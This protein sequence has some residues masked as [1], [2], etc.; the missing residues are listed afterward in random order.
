MFVRRALCVVLVCVAGAASAQ[1]TINGCPIFPAN[2][3]WNVP[4]DGLPVDA[5]SAAILSNMNPNAGLHP[6]FGSGLWDGG[7]IGIPFDA[8]PQSQALVAIDFE[9]LGWPDE[10]DAGPYPIPPDPQ[11]EGEPGA[12]NGDRH[13]LLVQ[14]GTCILWELYYTYPDGENGCDAPSNGWCAASGAKWDLNSNALRPDTW[15]SGDAAGLP[16]L[17]G[18]VRFEEVVAGEIRHALRFTVAPTRQ[19]Y[20]WPAR[21]EAG[22]T[23]N[24]DYP[25]MG[26]RVRLKAGVDLGGFSPHARTILTAL[27]K[28]GMMVADNGGDW[29]ISGIPN[30]SWDNDVLHEIGAIQGS[31]FEVVD[32]SS[33]M[34]DPNSGATSSSPPPPP[35]SAQIFAN[36]FEAGIASLAQWSS[37]VP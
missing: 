25:S 21:H 2:N 13:V 22:S 34:V 16:I 6:D 7:K 1:Q 8:V 9:D 19:A 29:F 17:A 33:L 27:K 3:I 14:A 30:E 11:I 12:A 18:L 28:Y 5:N 37:A 4:I 36:G 10:S 35:P 15:T 20:R 31:D 32:V 26:L 23:T 24:P